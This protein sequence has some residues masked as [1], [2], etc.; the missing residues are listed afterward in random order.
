MSV[1][2]AQDRSLSVQPG[3]HVRTAWIDIN[4]AVL[5]SRVRMGTGDVDAALRKLLCLGDRGS[6]PPP[7]GH[8]SGDRFVVCDGRHEYLASLM[9]G[10]ERLFVA[11]LEAVA[12]NDNGTSGEGV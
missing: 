7:V 2:T 12:A 5:G 9:L 10:R 4:Q 3:Q 8:W 11:W 6:W 1:W